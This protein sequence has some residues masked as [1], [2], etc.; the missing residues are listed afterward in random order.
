M[1]EAVGSDRFQQIVQR[2]HL[3][4]PQG[5]FVVRRHEDDH[6]RS[7]ARQ[8]LDDLESVELGDLNVEEDEI[9]C[10]TTDRLHGRPAV[11]ALRHDL[12]LGLPS[13]E[14]AQLAEGERL[15]ASVRR[16]DYRTALAGCSDSARAT[17]CLRE[18]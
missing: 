18:A 1:P 2:V 10:I 7:I 13:D 17:R 9:G 5:M 16:A 12:N 6:R 8:R 3:E 14:P 4:R 15:V 11:T